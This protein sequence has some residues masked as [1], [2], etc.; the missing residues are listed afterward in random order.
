MDVIAPSVGE[1]DRLAVRFGDW[2][3]AGPTN[4]RVTGMRLRF[5]PPVVMQIGV[6]SA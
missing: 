2:R 1:R 3:S 5:V 4:C 6:A